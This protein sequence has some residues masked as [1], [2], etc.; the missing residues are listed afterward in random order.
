MADG[1]PSGVQRIFH[2]FAAVRKVLNFAPAS[3]RSSAFEVLVSRTAPLR[4]RLV[5]V[6]FV[7]ARRWKC[8]LYCILGLA[9]ASLLLRLCASVAACVS[10]EFESGA[11][12]RFQTLVFGIGVVRVVTGLLVVVDSGSLP[13]R[14]APEA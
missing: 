5:C 2:L 11:S 7:Q 3:S 1:E 8:G 12:F 14:W 6:C 9:D 10:S 4:K 13:P